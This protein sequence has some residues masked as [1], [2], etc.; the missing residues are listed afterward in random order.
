VRR[1]LPC[2]CCRGKH[3]DGGVWIRL[4][5][6]RRE[7]RFTERHFAEAT[8]ST[9]RVEFARQGSGTLCSMP[10]QLGGECRAAGK[11]HQ[12]EYSFK[13][14]SLS[15]TVAQRP[16][17]RQIWMTSAVQ[18]PSRVVEYTYYA[19]LLNGV[20]GDALGLPTRLLGGGMLGVLAI[21][22]L[23]RHRERTIELYGAI[24]SP[25]ACGLL[26]VLL[27]V[28]VHEESILG[29]YVRPFVI[30]LFGL[31]ITRSLVLR[32]D[33]L[34]RFV[35]V[36]F[37][38]GL[39]TLP[40]LQVGQDLDRARLSSTSIG[41]PND[42]AQWFGFCAT[43]FT[44]VAFRKQ[45]IG[46]RCL[47]WVAT[48]ACLGIIGLTV[49]RGALLAFV[50]AGA[51]AARRFVRT[52]FAP[53]VLLLVLGGTLYELGYF[54]RAIASY[55]ARGLED[56]GRITVW[57]RA[58]ARFIESP[59]VGVGVS[60]ADTY[61]PEKGRPITPHNSF[62][63]IA[64]TAGL[65]PLL[66]F[67]NYWLRCARAALRSIYDSGGKDYHSPLFV[68]SLLTVQSGNFGFTMPW[69]IAAL[70][71]GL[72]ACVAV[73]RFRRLRIPSERQR[74]RTSPPVL[75]DRGRR[76]EQCSTTDPHRS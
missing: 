14:M 39:S 57:P 8:C 36:S 66:F 35:M 38:I 19:C 60:Y 37:L 2:I 52:G 4:A 16:L 11:H 56:T 69:M 67:I 59:F 32:E 70:T 30:W 20:M 72:P 21:I 34:H 33:F 7:R 10:L 47:Y 1:S 18:T 43:Y 65:V 23:V 17:E 54:E 75:A 71:I 27:Q 6:R 61:V 13:V 26:F 5:V 63:F 64:L 55:E 25:I 49:S 62:L 58:I 40:F 22:C 50:V 53:L 3:V 42:L 73:R 15:A 68:Y 45:P 44:V 76:H 9:R 28:A 29:E 41:N 51:I 12:I 48:F 46:T 24:A 31:I 74:M